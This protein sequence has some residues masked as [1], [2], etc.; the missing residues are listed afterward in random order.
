MAAATV[1]GE[2]S[3]SSAAVN[4]S[5]TIIGPPHLGQRQDGEPLLPEEGERKS[6]LEYRERQFVFFEVLE[7]ESESTEVSE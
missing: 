3:W 6:I 4:R 5:M 7:V 1:G 2:R